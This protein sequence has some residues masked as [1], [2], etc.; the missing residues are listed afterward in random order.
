MGAQVRPAV[1]RQRVR[2]TPI[3]TGTT[4]GACWMI[5]VGKR[6]RRREI[7]AI[8]PTYPR[9]RFR[10]NPVILTKPLITVLAGEQDRSPVA[11]QV[12]TRMTGQRGPPLG[13]RPATQCISE[14]IDLDNVA[15]AMVLWGRRG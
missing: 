5:A 15:G 7:S 6:C 1:C 13:T 10:A 9:P 14:T 3:R 2:R 4:S 11:D 12:R 8:A